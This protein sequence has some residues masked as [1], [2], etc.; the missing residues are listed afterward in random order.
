[1]FVS[2][3]GTI[4]AANRYA[5]EALNLT[6]E[7]PGRELTDFVE[8]APETLARAL[9]TWSRS[10]DP[11][12]SSFT[13]SGHATRATFSAYGSV[14]FPAEEGA[15]AV[16]LVRFLPRQESNPFVLLNQKIAELNTEISRRAQIQDALRQS[17]AALQERVAEAEALSRSKDEFLATVSHE[18]RTPLNAILGW[19]SLL[20]DQMND[21][22]ARKGLEVIHRN[23]EAQAR[24]IDDILDVSRIITGKLR[25]ETQAC[26]L[27][28]IAQEAI[29]AV[30]PSA[31]AKQ[32]EL[33]LEHSGYESTMLI[34]DPNRLRQVVWNLLSNAVKFTPRQGTVL[35]RVY[36]DGSQMALSVADDGQGMDPSFLPSVFERF[37]QAD[38]STTRRSGGL[39]LGL[40]L[41]RYIVEAHGGKVHV[42]S[43]GLGRGATFTVNLPVQALVTST[44]SPPIAEAEAISKSATPGDKR[45]P[46]IRVLVVDDEADARELLMLALERAGAQVMTASSTAEALASIPTFRP[47]LI[48][49][50]IGMP[51]EDG[52]SF[53]RRLRQLRDHDGHAIPALA[54]TAYTRIED[55]TRALAAGFTTHLG[56][57]VNPDELVAVLANLAPL[58]L[59]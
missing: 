16:L 9:R 1:M 35:V 44:D 53:V 10:P 55:H 15:P 21:A 49:S 54:L 36:R 20:R 50:D 30:R 51:D 4:L 31:A 43:E 34:A 58:T 33:I 19:S 56:K 5:R 47:Q 32:I 42:H 41:V 57:P 11:I 40:A 48:V 24:I 29:E 18:L 37:K 14:A 45:L 8:D 38:S 23:A 39:G 2:A 17:E 26:D 6:S 3:R 13:L 27:A 59:P 25:L 7:R 52:Y 22:R 28:G 12:P 46:G